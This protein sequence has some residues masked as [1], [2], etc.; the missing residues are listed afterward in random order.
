M[1]VDGMGVAETE[2][3]VAT[4]TTATWTW[5]GS[6]IVAVEDVEE[7]AVGIMDPA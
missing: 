2:A 7:E 6:I 4:T 3:V 5:A 1:E